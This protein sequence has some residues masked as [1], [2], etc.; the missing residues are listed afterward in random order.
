MPCSYDARPSHSIPETETAA[1]PMHN[2][3][4]IMVIICVITVSCS[5]SYIASRHPFLP[6]F[7][8]PSYILRLPP[9]QRWVMSSGST[10]CS[11]NSSSRCEGGAPDPILATFIV[12]SKDLLSNSTLQVI[13]QEMRTIP[14][15]S[16]YSWQF[17]HII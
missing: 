4:V 7:R 2:Y 13:F 14:K 5:P 16:V 17:V 12:L 3:P 15:L 8:T 1:A 10:R 11:V 9:S 6:A